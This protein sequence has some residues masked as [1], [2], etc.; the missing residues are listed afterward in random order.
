MRARSTAASVCP[1]R[2]S[3]PPSLA[4]SG[5]RW[6]GR[7]K[8]V[9]LLVGSQIAWIVRARSAAVMPVRRRAVVDRHGVVRAQ[10]GRV[11]LDHRRQLEP[12]AHVGQDR[13]AELPPAVR[14][15]EVDDLR[16]HLLG[17]ADEVAFVLAVFGV[18]DHDDAPA[19]DGVDGFFDRGKLRGHRRFAAV[20]SRLAPEPRQPANLPMQ[21]SDVAGMRN[22][23]IL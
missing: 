17:G 14:D 18:D 19:V 21:A 23:P 3:T 20:A 10:R 8:S 11:G 1:A 13:H 4:T 9:G 5:N 15:H 22:Q 2:R 6:P 12:L 16:R 7:M